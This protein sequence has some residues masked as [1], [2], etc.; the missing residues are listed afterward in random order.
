MNWTEIISGLFDLVIIPL[1][2]AASGYLISYIRLKKQE[3]LNRTENETHKKY[4]EMLDKTITDCV[5]ATT[6]TYVESLKKQNKFDA[7]AQKVAF[8]QTYEA[9]MSILTED[10]K[11]Y[12]TESVNDLD[13]YIKNK[14]ESKVGLTK[15]SK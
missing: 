4:I 14:I 7:D 8:K 12:L 13:I 6:Q 2:I 9:I 11:E 3:L 5:T 1:L 15:T 10:A